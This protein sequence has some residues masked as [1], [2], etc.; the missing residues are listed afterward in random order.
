MVQLGTHI[1]HNLFQVHTKYNV[2]TEFKANVQTPLPSLNT[3]FSYEHVFYYNSQNSLS[4]SLTII[5]VSTEEK[6]QK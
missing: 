6:L 3:Y 5:Q 1:I 4:V 2:T